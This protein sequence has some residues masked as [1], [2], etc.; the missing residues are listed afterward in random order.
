MGLDERFFNVSCLLVF[1]P[2][3]VFADLL[4]ANVDANK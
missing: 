1:S 4:V 3:T 2:K